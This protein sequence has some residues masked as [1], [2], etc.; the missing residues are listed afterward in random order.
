MFTPNILTN[1]DKK[2]QVC[3]GQVLSVSSGQV[4]FSLKYLMKQNL[5]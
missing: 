3:L 2:L 5:L 1:I 4:G